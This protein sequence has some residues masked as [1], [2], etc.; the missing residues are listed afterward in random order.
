MYREPE[1]QRIKSGVAGRAVAS[2]AT[3]WAI[4]KRRREI[5]EVGDKLAMDDSMDGGGQLCGLGGIRVLSDALMDQ[6]EYLCFPYVQRT[7]FVVLLLVL[8]RIVVVELG[9]EGG[10]A[11]VTGETANGALLLIV[12]ARTYIVLGTYLGM[13]RPV[14]SVQWTYLPLTVKVTRN[15]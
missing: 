6:Y 12:V 5:R 13:C 3:G 1:Y 14:Y 9:C 10:D 11:D 4:T 7:Y 2:H 15:A 8:V